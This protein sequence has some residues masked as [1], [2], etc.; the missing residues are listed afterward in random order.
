MKIHDD[1]RPAPPDGAEFLDRLDDVLGELGA[2]DTAPATRRALARWVAHELAGGLGARMLEIADRFRLAADPEALDDRWTVAA[3]RAR[4]ALERAAARLGDSSLLAVLD[5][6]DV[7]LAPA[8]S[9][10]MT[11]DRSAYDEAVGGARVDR[12]AWWGWRARVDD[13][14]PEP[15]LE[16][17]LASLRAHLH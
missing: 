16:G 11:L 2:P 12:D 7:E 5:D 17:V 1:F 6:L 4:I 9:A 8:R 10:L 14:L 13:A 3:V 15:L